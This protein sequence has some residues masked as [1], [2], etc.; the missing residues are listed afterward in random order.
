MPLF[1]SPDCSGARNILA[2]C[3][4]FASAQKTSQTRAK[5]QIF[6]K[7]ADNTCFLRVFATFCALSHTL[8]KQL[9]VQATQ[10]IW[11]RKQRENGVQGT[12]LRVARGAK[13]PPRTGPSGGN[14]QKACALPLITS[15]QRTKGFGNCI[16]KDVCILCCAHAIYI[17]LNPTA[18]EARL[19]QCGVR[20]N[21]ARQTPLCGI[22]HTCRRRM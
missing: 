18:L 7:S 6:D 2:V 14:L 12:E 22:R 20:E 11:A 5:T 16:Q 4:A 1:R 13:A 19:S 15:W 8:C 9:K 17:P 3:R 10:I 21:C